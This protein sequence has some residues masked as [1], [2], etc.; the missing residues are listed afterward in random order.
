M[1][2]GFAYHK[3][4]FDKAGEPVDFTFLEVNKT[5]E[6]YMG[7]TPEKVIGKRV[8]KIF[9]G[10]LNEETIWR[11]AFIQSIKNES[12]ESFEFYHPDNKKW[13]RVQ[14][15]PEG[16]ESLATEFIDITAEKKLK[17]KNPIW[18]DE[19]PNSTLKP[20]SLIDAV[21]KSVE[22][23]RKLV[24]SLPG[25]VYNCM[26]DEN[27]TMLYMSE[28]AE[29]ITGYP[30]SDFVDN[31]E[32]T[33][34]SIIHRGDT[35]HV[36]RKVMEGV[37][38]EKPWEVEYRIIHRDGTVRWIWEKGQPIKNDDGNLIY[39]TGFLQD[40][41]KSKKQE[42]GYK[43]LIDGMNDTAFV[44][45]F[46][47]N[48]I[49]VNDTA[50]KNLGYAREELLA[51]SPLDIDPN[52][53][54]E[55]I[56]GLI[57]DMK[58]DEKQ[59]FE[60]QHRTKQGK[61]IPVEISSSL[62]TYQG[63]K[64]VLSIARD[65]TQRKKAEKALREN[66]ERFKKLFYDSPVPVSLSKMSDSTYTEVNHA[67]CEFTG[68]T[69]EEAIGHDIEEL[70]IIDH[71]TRMKL[72]EMYSAK[73]SINAEITIYT[74]RDEEMV[75]I[76]SVETF[77]FNDEEYAINMMVDITERKRA[78]NELAKS[79]ELFEK[80]IEV[81]PSPVMLH[82]EDG[83]V[84][85]I[86]KAWTEITGYSRQEIPTIDDWIDK[87]YE[88]EKDKVLKVIKNLFIHKGS[89][90]EGEFEI[91]TKNG[92]K[93]T[94]DFKS[95][96][97]GKLPDGR[98]LG[99]SIAT[100]ITERKGIEE[101]L[102]S[103]LKDRETLLT[104]IHHR[105]KNNLAVL[106]GIMQL[107]AFQTEDKTLQNRLYE[108]VA[109][110]QTM[111]TVHEL[112]YKSESFASLTFSDSIRELV[113]LVSDTF[114]IGDTV[115]TEVTSDTI[116]LNV[117]QALPASLIVNEVVTNAYEH[118]FIDRQSGTLALKLSEKKNHVFIE[119]IDDGTGIPEQHPADKNTFG[120][121]LIKIL[122][123]QLHGSFSYTNTGNGTRFTLEF[124]KANN[125]SGSGSTMLK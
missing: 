15:W 60:T 25:I 63:E 11:K 33:Y 30:A 85:K 76:F 92:L 101:N 9:P 8:S 7:L 10:F 108:S 94:W 66:E 35:E 99:K 54:D 47:G 75:V 61:I 69:R 40:I 87:A 119:I 124:K 5:F 96:Y 118:A 67:W 51:M 122:T 31:A 98:K 44:I 4:I 77:T 45:D 12:I 89:A 17:S 91:K 29:A 28:Q 110:I 64:A 117:N 72:R 86:N 104:E 90:A 120:M 37:T 34:E 27:W 88:V 21:R 78:E 114:E 59:I 115:K 14:V 80:A 84:I 2:F 73:G 56:S 23:Y 6:K 24:S 50:V 82:A 125:L 116:A 93:R 13:L 3:I 22:E 18:I 71:D 106:S 46:D 62:V 123:N 81:A 83:E 79:R 36:T 105:V 100:D 58:V 1:S 57:K 32:R 42:R 70:N 26:Y 38:A 107:E 109:R 48:F 19:L 16:K 52:L 95:A 53:N 65:I 74:K 49:E 111:A 20:G 41:T 113:T 55:E 39:L 68:F 102:R 97:I 112:L 121:T 43:S 103:A